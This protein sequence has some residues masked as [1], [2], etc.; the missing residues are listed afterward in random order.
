MKYYYERN[1]EAVKPVLSALWS[2]YD[3]VERAYTELEFK[4]VASFVP[5]LTA[6]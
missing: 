1:V 6:E 2:A 3:F 4:I 5:A